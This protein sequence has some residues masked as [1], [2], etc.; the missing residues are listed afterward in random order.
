MR[1]QYCSDLH[2]EFAQNNKFL[3]KNPLKV[4]GDI[5]ILAGDI[6]PFHDDFLNY[7]FFNYISDSYQWVFWL[8]GNHEFYYKD[9]S[10]FN[11]SY[12]ILIRKNISFVNNINIQLENIK[13]VFSTL[14]SKISSDKEKIIEQCIS[15]FG[16]I[17]NKNKT[18][19]I[20][21]YNNLHSR[22]RGFIETSIQNNLPEIVV[23]HH[24]PSFLCNSPSHRNSILND[25]FCVDLTD[26]IQESNVK[27]WIYGHS[28]FNQK[29]VYIGN[30][31][32][33]TNQLGYVHINEH[34]SFKND[35]YFVL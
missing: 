24:L 26:Y 4:S 8:P 23:T 34:E 15:D 5:L 27:F 19:N 14:W 33:L 9:I 18:L 30:S 31:L 10:E 13:F 7:S 20:S 35:C 22:C 21:D 1:I 12:N 32:L 6:V 16:C 25:A 11:T 2:L 29:P 3:T 28:H 17:S